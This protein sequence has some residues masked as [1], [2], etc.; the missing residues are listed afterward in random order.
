MTSFTDPVTMPLWVL[1]LADIAFSFVSAVVN[2]I[3]RAIRRYLL[4]DEPHA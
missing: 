3:I 4:G 2:E 1:L